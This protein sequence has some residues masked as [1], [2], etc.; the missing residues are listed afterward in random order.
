MTTQQ[1]PVN[2]VLV[3]GIALACLAAAAGLW[4]FAPPTANINMWKFG[5]ARIGIVMCAFWLALPSRNRQAAWANL[6]GGGLAVAALFLLVLT[7]VP[8]RVVL[9]LAIV[10]VIVSIVIRPKQRPSPGHTRR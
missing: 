7:R 10:T 4:V 6:S 9:P 8:L 5:F 3:G 1:Y 2:R